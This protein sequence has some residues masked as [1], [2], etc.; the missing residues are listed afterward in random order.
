MFD[1]SRTDI[2]KQI[3]RMSSVDSTKA[4]S[5]VIKCVLA[6][7]RKL[8]SLVVDHAEFDRDDDWCAQIATNQSFPNVDSASL[9]LLRLTHL[10]FDM[11]D[12]RLAGSR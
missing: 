10:F 1:L 6:E 5:H 9:L 2:D 7:A 12:W 4:F 11:I 3:E 8:K